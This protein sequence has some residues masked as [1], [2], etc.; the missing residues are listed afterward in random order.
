[1]PSL[2]ATQQLV[3]GVTPVLDAERYK[4]MTTDS[5]RESVGAQPAK[6]AHR[7]RGGELTVADIATSTMANIGPAFSFYFSFAGIVAESGIASPLTVLLAAVAIFLLGNTLSVFSVKM[8]TT[9]SFVSFI[10]RSLGTIPGVTV[11]V[12]LIVGYVIALGGVITAT[13]AITAMLLKN[14][15]H[16][17]VSWK[18]LALLFV[19]FAVVVMASGVRSSTR[20]AGVFFLVEMAVLVV[21]AVAVLVAHAGSINLQPFNPA[22]S[23]GGL[24][25]LG[26]GFPLAVFMFVGWENSATLAEE[27]ANPRRS[28]PRAIFASIALMAAT[29]LFVSYASIVGFDNSTQAI[30]HADIPFVDLATSVS[31]ILGVL[32]IAAGFTSTVSVLIAAANSQ[33]RLLFNAGRERLLP[34]ALGTVTARGQVPLVSYLVFFVVALALTFGY[35]WNKD[36]LTAFND[37]VTLG[38]ILITVV[39]LVANLALP[40]SALRDDRARLNVVRHVVLPLLGAA[41]LVYPLY[42]L[43]Q[44]GQEPP[45]SYFPA[46]TLGVVIVALIYATIL[47]FVDPRVGDRLGSILADH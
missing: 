12:T 30:A 42:D 45:T 26:L 35:G 19:V 31:S 5:T 3:T 16:V 46:I 32:A 25:G 13:G 8:P 39:Y 27:T 33:T 11:A 22:H 1:M 20:V 7:L 6:R 34:A 44:P 40:V 15:V 29:Y 47:R 2:V 41:A 14:V 38:T 37:L 36:P 10:G 43:L 18:L 21:V 9:G 17:D 23:P 24:M 28:I 4:G